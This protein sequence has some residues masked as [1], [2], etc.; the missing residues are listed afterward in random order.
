MT[1]LERLGQSLFWTHWL[2]LALADIGRGSPTVSSEGR[3]E[4]RTR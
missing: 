3:H 2:S 4:N 1:G